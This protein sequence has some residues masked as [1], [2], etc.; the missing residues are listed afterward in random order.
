MGDPS[1]VLRAFERS[2][3][4][5]IGALEDDSTPAA[6]L[7]R[8]SARCATAFDAVQAREAEL[9]GVDPAALRRGRERIASLHALARQ[10]A[11]RA[12]ATTEH[13]LTQARDTRRALSNLRGEAS[14]HGGACDLEG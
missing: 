14:P 6:A 4:D 12:A 8:A 9:Q 1:E 13:S 11:E 7:E 3:E 2:L 5:L 10:A